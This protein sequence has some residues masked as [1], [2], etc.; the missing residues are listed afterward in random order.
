MGTVLYSYTRTLTFLNF[1]QGMG[2]EVGV[3]KG[4]EVGVGKGVEEGRMPRALEQRTCGGVGEVGGLGMLM[5]GGGG[6]WR[7]HSCARLA[8]TLV[9]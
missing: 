5:V 3:G 4:L 8:V 7:R 2:L 9:S 6:V 1:C